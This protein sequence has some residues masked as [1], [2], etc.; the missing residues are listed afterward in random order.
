MLAESHVAQEV[1]L[2]KL[3]WRRMLAR[4]ER[5]RRYKSN[6]NRIEKVAAH[7]GLS[8]TGELHSGM[9]SIA[10]PKDILRHYQCL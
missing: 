4:L 3:Y 5:F 1:K 10:V 7:I 2:C 8:E 6:L 9:K